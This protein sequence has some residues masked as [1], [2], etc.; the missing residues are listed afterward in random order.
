MDPSPLIRTVQELFTWRASLDI[1]LIAAGFFVLYHT[2]RTTG[3]WKIAVGVLLALGVFAAARVL[4]L[5]GLEWIFSNVSS[6]AL[7]GLIVIFQPEIRKALERTASLRRTDAGLEETSLAHVFS[8]AAFALAQLRRG[9]IL[10]FPGREPIRPWISEGIPLSARASA[11]LVLSLFDPHSPGH[12]GAVVVEKGRLTRFSVRLPLSTTGVLPEHLGTRHHAAMGLSEAT[13]ALVIAVSEERGVVSLF[14]RGR[15]LRLEDKEELAGKILSH[16]RESGSYDLAVRYRQDRWTVIREATVAVVAA[17]VFWSAFV[18]AGARTLSMALTLPVEYTGTPPGA[19]LAGPRVSEVQVHLAGPASELERIVPSELP[20][21]IDLSGAEPGRHKFLLTERSLKLPPTVK[22]L[23]AQPSTVEVALRAIRALDVQVRPNL[24]GKLARGL[25]I[26]S[27]QV[28]PRTIA[29]LSS[30]GEES[31]GASA[32]TTTPIDLG[33]LKGSTTVYAQVLAPPGLE[34][35][36]KKWPQVAVRI[37]LKG[38]RSEG[39]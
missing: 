9:A 20:V 27:L 5:R 14:S 6:V 38:S 35:A 18:V 7:I 30:L 8:E 31:L 23:D 32:V 3:T 24:V 17:I 28:S 39:G 34:P 29:A 21:R 25:R 26:V 22:L 12:D 16:W 2:L 11:P 19:A 15:M 1:G 37:V 10:V 36:D 33:A 4:H 13:D